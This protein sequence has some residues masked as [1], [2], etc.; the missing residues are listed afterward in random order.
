M[1]KER[2]PDWMPDFSYATRVA[3]PSSSAPGLRVSRASSNPPRS[4]N[5]S[6]DEDSMC[7]ITNRCSPKAVYTMVSKLSEFKKQLIRDIGF[8]GILDLPCINKVNLRL[9]AWLLTKL[10][11]EDSELV[12]SESRRIY[13]HERDVG[14]VFGLPCGEIDVASMDVTSEQIESIK[15]L[16]GLNSKDGRSF[17]GVEF[18][19]EKHLDDRSS[20]IER[21]SFK[22]A[23]VIF[24]MGHLLAPSAKYDCGN[25]DFW[26]ALKDTEMLERM[27][28]CRYVYS[29]VLDAAQKARDEMIRKNRVTNLYGCHL[30]LQVLFLDNVDIRG[31]NKKHNILPR[32]SVFD[33]ESLKTMATMCESRD[34]SN[35]NSFVGLRAPN[36]T[37]YMRHMYQSVHNVTRRPVTPLPHTPLPLSSTHQGPS[38]QLTAETY[39]FREHADFGSYIRARYPTLNKLYAI[40]YIRM[41][42]AKMFREITS[43]RSSVMRLNA[44]LLDWLV[45]NV[46]PVHLAMIHKKPLQSP[47]MPA[48]AAMKVN[49]PSTAEQHSPVAVVATATGGTAT[50]SRGFGV[51]PKEMRASET[52]KRAADDQ[53]SVHVKK[54]RLHI[55]GN[56]LD[57]ASVG[58]S[59]TSPE[60]KQMSYQLGMEEYVPE[61]GKKE[62][63][64]IDPPSFDLGIDTS[65]LADPFVTPKSKVAQIPHVISPIPYQSG[66]PSVYHSAHSAVPP[67]PISST[68]NFAQEVVQDMIDTI[69]DGSSQKEYVLYG[70]QISENFIRQPFPLSPLPTPAWPSPRQEECPEAGVLEMLHIYVRD[71][72]HIDDMFIV[73]FVSLWIVH[74]FPKQLVISARDIK[75]NFQT[76]K[77][78]EFHIVDAIIR[79]L[80]Q[81]DVSVA[82]G[83]TKLRWRHFLES[84]FG[85]QSIAG[86]HPEET[87]SVLNQFIHFDY[88]VSYCK[89]IIIPVLVDEIW[90]AYMFDLDEDV[91]HILDP[92]HCPSR[93]AVHAH[94]QKKIYATME[95]CFNAFFTGYTMNPEQDLQVQYPKLCDTFSRY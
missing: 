73:L 4:A 51:Q 45:S 55:G 43:F 14:I 18:V 74:P 8:G 25:L 33:A 90:A 60:P 30:F 62:Y 41:H 93:Y 79:R 13:V 44:K 66:I 38:E 20:R 63:F 92:G 2:P 11:T 80:N 57:T 21:D 12:I 28:W 52:V 10:D 49:I 27:N 1:A 15:S 81:T 46:D 94:F 24:V 84:D 3:H 29:H 35:F 86:Y 26:G 36:S 70:Q 82:H 40:D 83:G 59:L 85:M 72:K 67:S 39:T 7:N 61:H 23:F 17:K 87:Q 53:H 68:I 48:D 22:I 32:I 58:A 31:L 69:E 89:K 34:G 71:S 50:P 54:K 78:T 42:N 65:P 56:V 16:C 76:P 95:R 9:S 91:V 77:L 64:T 6:D 5:I 75:D 19:L 47:P 37:A 88:S